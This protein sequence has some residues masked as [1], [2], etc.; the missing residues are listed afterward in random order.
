M[1]ERDIVERLRG[2]KKRPTIEL[3]LGNGTITQVPGLGHY[4]EDDALHEEAAAEILRLRSE[5][6][7]AKRLGWIAGRDAAAS[8]VDVNVTDSGR[9]FA[10]SI[11]NMEP[12]A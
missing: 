11:R 3:P 8:Y 5:L 12:P 2:R 10:Q 7:G 6:A 4:T 9:V 1:S